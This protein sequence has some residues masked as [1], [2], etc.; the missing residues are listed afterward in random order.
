MNGLSIA[1]LSS[2][3]TCLFSWYLAHDTVTC[4]VTGAGT[5]SVN[6]YYSAVGGMYFKRG[7]SI[8]YFPDIFQILALR[9]DIGTGSTI[10]MTKHFWVIS[11]D[12]RKDVIY[13]NVPEHPEEFIS[14]P[15]LD[16]WVLD[17]GKI[18]APKISNC[19]GSLQDSPSLP[20]ASPSNIGQ[21]IE[22]PVTSLLLGIIFYVAYYL[23]SQRTEVSLVSFSY[24][25][26][27]NQKE[28]YRMVTA[29]FSHF[30][31][32]HLL[33]N[34]MSLFQLGELEVTYGSVTFA[35]LNADL[36]F[37]TMGICIL[38]SHL[39][40]FKF[41]R[42]DQAYQ[43]AVGFSCVL[44]AWMVAASVRMKQY[45]PI[46]LLPTLCF[47]TYYI[48]NPLLYFDIGPSLGFPVN[49]G[50]VILLVITKVI[51]PRSSFLGHLSGIIIGYP[52]A[53]NLLNWLTPPL[54][55]S[56]TAI[57]IILKDNLIPNRF[58]GYDQ[59][60]DLNDL[61]STEIIKKYKYLRQTMWTLI[62][63]SAIS[64]YTFSFTQILPRVVMIYVVWGA[65]QSRRCEWLSTL[66]TTHEDCLLCTAP[67]TTYIITTL[68][69]ICVKL[70]V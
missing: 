13:K 57:S 66:R 59:N 18:P 65:V 38:C 35:Y 52:V 24:D 40:I 17:S 55:L 7:E 62:T 27:V 36:V 14:Q 47:S 22:R 69:N 1:I 10:A 53:W 23:W 39:M 25:S 29:S 9:Q 4:N 46:F 70:K 33:F 19:R 68:G 41:N 15:P 60:T 21:M 16:G 26:V 58:I 37:I 2:I 48:P 51:I 32:W 8:S 43:Q 50:P 63:L 31:A 11:S 3:G 20:S 54:A 64:I 49:I 61:A 30:D 6:G 44:F 45:C 12:V 42:T 67:H 34:T 28:Y 56:I 5:A